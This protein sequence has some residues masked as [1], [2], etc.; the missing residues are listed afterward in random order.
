MRTKLHFLDVPKETKR[1]DQS[2]EIMTSNRIP[3]ES[4][5]NMSKAAD[6][7]FRTTIFETPKTTTT[8]SRAPTTTFAPAQTPPYAP[9][10]LLNSIDLASTIGTSKFVF[11]DRRQMISPK[12]A[13]SPIVGAGGTG[14]Q[15]V[16][17]SSANGGVKSAPSIYRPI[18]PSR[19]PAINPDRYYYNRQHIR[20]R[21]PN[22]VD[23]DDDV[24]YY[25]RS[26][27][28]DEHH[29]PVGGYYPYHGGETSTEFYQ[30]RRPPPTY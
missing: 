5:V 6:V 28:S 18:P 8:T 19:R 30:R 22:V 23:L 21:Y 4:S 3:I 20:H 29:R 26:S 15:Y 25:G 9:P 13:L 7:S 10:I 14:R 27:A 12:I 1:V 2:S 16:P 17:A 11:T 24:G